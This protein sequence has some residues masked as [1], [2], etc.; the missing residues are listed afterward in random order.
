MPSKTSIAKRLTVVLFVLVSIISTNWIAYGET[1]LTLRFFSPWDTPE[2]PPPPPPPDTPTP[3]IPTVTA[4]GDLNIRSGPGIEYDVVGFMR[5][6]DSALVVGTTAVNWWKIECPGHITGAECWVSGDPRYSS[7]KNTEN[8]PWVS[9]PPTP[10]PIPATPTLVPPTPTQ[11]SVP[12]TQTSMP[13]SPPLTTTTSSISESP[14]PDPDT[15][16]NNQISEIDETNS[17][18]DLT[19]QTITQEPTS[20]PIIQPTV[21]QSPTPNIY[22]WGVALVAISFLVLGLAIGL[23]LRRKS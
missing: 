5:G 18:D 21:E 17:N 1:A 4:L 9:V 20:N 16:A 15:T 2:P 19:S 23:I 8:I 22:Y 6:G 14:T 10:S 13:T 12:P 7:A 3:S 11:T